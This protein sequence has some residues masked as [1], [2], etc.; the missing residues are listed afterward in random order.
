M[1]KN[2]VAAISTGIVIGLCAC[3]STPST[4][5]ENAGTSAEAL[6]PQADAY[7]TTIDGKETALFYLKNNQGATAAVTNLG[8]RLV[9]LVVPDKQGKL[10]NVV[11]G[12]DSVKAYQKPSWTYFGATIGRFGNRIAK[13]TFT[14]D[15]TSYQLDRNNGPNSLHGGKDGMWGKVWDAKQI[16]DSVVEFKYTSPDMEA[17][18]PGTL[19]TTVTF[20]LG[21]ENALKIDYNATTDKAGPVNLTNHAYFNLNGEGTGSINDHLLTINSDAITAVDG[22]LI[23]T[24]EKMPVAGTPF[25]FNTATAIGAR[26]DS[27]HPQLKLGLGYDHNYILKDSSKNEHLAATVYGPTTGIF[28]EVLTTE[29]GVQ[30]YGGN[31]MTDADKDGIKGKAYPYR[32]GFC[33]ETQHFPDSPNQSSFPSTIL[34][35]GETYSTSTTYKFSVK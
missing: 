22:T 14:V 28:M 8:A 2:L 11:L 1:K 18:Y 26:I 23:P 12:M 24:G 21:A 19:S 13:A 27:A 4:D 29:P 30:F 7:K 25:D 6:L 32:N 33:L 10:V 20:S 34:K 5:T 3:N 16:S 15:G 17:G 35:P 9:G 31:F